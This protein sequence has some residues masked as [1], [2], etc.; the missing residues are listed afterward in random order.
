MCNQG[1]REGR[2]AFAAL[3]GVGL[4]DVGFD[5]QTGRFFVLERGSISQ[6]SEQR[7][8]LSQG[9]AILDRDHCQNLKARSGVPEVGG[10]L[11]MRGCLPICR[12]QSVM[13]MQGFPCDFLLKLKP[14][15]EQAESAAIAPSMGTRPPISSEAGFLT[16]SPR[17]TDEPGVV[18]I[19]MLVPGWN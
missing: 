6:R 14:E 11:F 9:R 16:V 19:V 15:L 12:S 1:D 5:R 2:S 13:N 17:S 7:C 8:F 10:G 18:E 3:V 4:I